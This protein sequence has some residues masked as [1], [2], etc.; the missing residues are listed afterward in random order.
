VRVLTGVDNTPATSAIFS[1]LPTV[2]RDGE[3]VLKR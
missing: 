2:L 3:L 1:A